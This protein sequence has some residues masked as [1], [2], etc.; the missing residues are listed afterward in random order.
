MGGHLRAGLE[1]VVPTPG[2][3]A[4]GNVELVRRVVDIARAQGRSTATAA[5]VRAMFRAA[6][7]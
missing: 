5:E 6:R 1:D 3:P 4:V 2:A 7:S